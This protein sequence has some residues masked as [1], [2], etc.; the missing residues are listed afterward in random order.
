MRLLCY[1]LFVFACVGCQQDAELQKKV[2]LGEAFG[3]TYTIQY[4]TK[5]NFNAEKQ[6]DSVLYAV[7]RSMSTYMAQSDISKI[8][9][10]DST[11][12]V[13]ALFKE[14]WGISEVVH[15]NAMG[16]FDPTVGSLRNLYGFG[17][18][19]YT[20]V[21]DKKVLDSVRNLVGFQ[22]VFIQEDGTLHKAH[23]DIYLDF[24]AVAKGYGIDC[25]GNMLSSNNVH[26]FIIEL[27]GEVLAKGQNQGKKKPWTSGVE[28]ITSEVDDRRAVVYFKLENRGLAGSGNYRKFRIDDATGQKYVHTIN[29]LTGRAEQNNVTSATVMAPTC[30]LADAYA[31]AC[32]AMG[33]EKAKEMLATLKEIDAYIT[34]VDTDGNDQTFITKGFQDAILD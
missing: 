2:L 18:V 34:Y 6:L 22:K 26:D 14:V 31:T 11:I 24:N 33:I 20:K 9:R 16:Y 4:F 25:I 10:G 12:V 30:A 15:K 1:I 32:M 29:P 13:D 7:N 3:T 17:D 28:S 23:P 19:G 27:G 5:D 21:I 8:N